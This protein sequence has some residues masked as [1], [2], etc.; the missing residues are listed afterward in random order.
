MQNSV[1]KAPEDLEIRNI[2][3][4]LAAFVA[5]NGNEFSNMT[6]LKQKDNPKFSFLFGGEYND[7]Y[8][9]KLATEHLILKKQQMEQNKQSTP[10]IQQLN[11]TQNWPQFN[12]PPPMSLETCNTQ[13]SYLQK[14]ITS[15]QDQLQQSEKNL[16]AQKEVMK[17][18]RKIQIDETIRSSNNEKLNELIKTTKIDLNELNRLTNSIIEACTK[19]AIASH[20]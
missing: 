18:K 1:P 9:Y 6:K 14:Q 7:Y 16:N 11:P 3:D 8:N 4:K 2:I 13:L 10:P 20:K 5:K 15:L 19:E 12:Q 17:I